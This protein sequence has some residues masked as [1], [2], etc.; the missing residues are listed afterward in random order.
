ML[1]L[2]SLGPHAKVTVLKFEPPSNP[3]KSSVTKNLTFLLQ[4]IYHPPGRFGEGRLGG[5]GGIPSK[6]ETK[7]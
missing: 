1:D 6:K 7:T 2:M 3:R 4:P 5:L